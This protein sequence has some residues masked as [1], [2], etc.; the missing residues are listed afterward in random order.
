MKIKLLLTLIFTIIFTLQKVSSQNE[1][2]PNNFFSTANT[3]A[4]T[5]NQGEIKG[6]IAT[7]G[8][9]DFY[10][11]EITQ[12][13]VFDVTIS[14]IT[15]GVDMDLFLYD[16]SQNLISSTG[17]NNSPN[18]TFSQLVCESGTYFF[19]LKDD[20]NETSNDLYNFK[21]RLDVSDIYECN[22]SFT[23]AALI[24]LNQT[25]NGKIKSTGD[26]DFY[27]VEIT[28]AGVFDVTISNITNG[29]D[30]DLFLYDSFQNLI[31]STGRNDSPNL[32]FSQLVCESGTYFFRLKDDGNETSNDLYNFKVELD[33][34]DIYECNNSF[35][36][37]SLIQLDQTIQAKIKDVGDEDYY[38]VEITQ[39]GVFDALV[40]N[41]TNVDMDLFLYDSSQNL[42][43]SRGASNGPNLNF[44]QLVCEPGI[45]FFRLKDDRNT[46]SSNDLYNFKV[47]LDTSDIYEC[48]NSFSDAS[49]IQLNQTIQAKIKNVGDEDFYK[50]EITQA[51]VFD[52]LVSNITDVDMD[53]F[54]YD[55]SQNFIAFRGASNRP[56]LNFSQLVCKPGIYFFRLKD[57][58]NTESSNDLYNFKVELN[59]SDIYECNNSFTEATPIALCQTYSAAIYGTADKDYYSFTAKASNTLDITLSKVPS[60]I[61]PVISIFDESQN[62]ITT[63]TGSTGVTLNYTFAP[64]I[65]GTYFLVVEESFNDSSNPELYELLLEDS[66][67][68]LSTEDFALNNKVKV[69]PNPVEENIRIQLNESLNF[70]EAIIYN[71]LGQKIKIFN[72][73]TFNISKLSKGIYHLEIVTDKGKVVKRFVKE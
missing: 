5:D 59:T 36:D 32:T 44:S 33:I 21:V 51:G 57:D 60:N 3:I 43:A 11:V 30:M 34:S 13:G 58:R 48:N 42:I 15:N 53:L 61:R 9:I 41:I 54:L 7:R 26:E 1:T 47:E 49:L 35:S 63:R 22:N 73:T 4:L 18:L 2:E 64:P 31:S 24:Q 46:E 14:N 28:Q 27:K 16:S 69:L 37:A 45:Y 38:K 25:V 23:D 40:S 12:A 56:S 67:C 70:K 20:G 10:K 50:V 66:S 8:D 29:V 68:T 19:R 17:R 55:S 72:A 65:D 39:A 52:A 62:R 71:T 6:A